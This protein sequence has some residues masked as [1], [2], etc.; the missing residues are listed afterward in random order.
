M[1]LPLAT[2][3]SHDLHQ[4]RWVSGNAVRI[5]E[6]SRDRFPD[7]RRMR[8]ELYQDLDPEFHEEEMELIF[9]SAEATCFIG[10]AES[11]TAIAMLELS[12]RNFVDG[13]LGGP[14][15]YVEGIYI[16]PG[17]R[18]RGYGR[19][20]IEFAASWF[21][22]KGCRDMAAD[23]ELTNSVAQD[24]LT[25]AGFDETYRIVHYKRSLGG[26]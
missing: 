20:L 1:T 2:L 12:L 18:K 6:I 25:R 21:R 4:P 26:M 7:W 13:C 14:V 24:F 15:G 19:E 9:S 16:V 17:H 8:Q 11:G 23:A 10:T 3:D 5:I 22:L